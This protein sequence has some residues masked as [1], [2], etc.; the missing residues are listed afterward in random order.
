MAKRNKQK[1]VDKLNNKYD[2]NV[3]VRQVDSWLDEVDAWSDKV[4]EEMEKWGEE[5]GKDME[6]W[7]EEF[8]EKF[9]AEMEKWGEEF[10]K[11]MEKWGEEFGEK[12]GK[13]MEQ[14]GEEFG[15][16]MEKW[17]EQ[18]EKDAEKWAEQYDDNGNRTLILRD[19]DKGLF[20]EAVI[21]AKKTIIIRMPK[22]TRTDIN[23][24]HGEV[25]MADA[26]DIK[27]NLNY[28]TLTAN[29]IDGGKTLIN[30]AYAPVYVNYWGN[31]MLDLKYVDD[32]KLN[33][34]AKINLEANSSNVNINSLSKEAF[35]SGSFGSLFINN[36]TN[37]FRSV[38]IVLE[39]TDATVSMPKAAFDF[40]FNGKKSRFKSPAALELTTKNKSDSR[41]LLKGFYKSDNS[42]RSVTINASY[43]NVNFNN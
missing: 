12:F 30:A 17:A 6:Q 33:T 8:G 28:A 9:G 40:Y 22:G 14:W 19:N 38:D 32:C 43:S 15:K 2:T 24:R 41:S 23:V 36:I 21:K 13:E 20:D 42:G 4:E 34:V 25:K 5:F 39:N 35:L 3:S 7:G 18:F 37:D 31:G 29:S 11:D 10:G 16:D 27:A 26:R 1:Y